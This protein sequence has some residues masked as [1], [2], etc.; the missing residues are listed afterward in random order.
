MLK[1]K[2]PYK[3][4]NLLNWQRDLVRWVSF[5]LRD[6]RRLRFFPYWLF[7]FLPSKAAF[8]DGL[9][10]IT[11]EAIDWL[12]S[13]LTKN[14]NVF[15]WGSGGSTLFFAKKAKNVVS[16]EHQPEWHSRISRK[17]AENHMANC[18]YILKEPKPSSNSQ[19]Y[20][21]SSPRYKNFSFEEYCKA[22]EPY[23]DNFFDLI[24][25]DGRA[26]PSCISLALKKLR[27]NGFLL[28]DDSNVAEYK[29]SRELLKDWPRKDFLGPKPYVL[30]FYQTTIWQKPAL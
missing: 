13:Y 23:P 8:K 22:I 10:W 25:I 19:N 17:L 5:V 29:G 21:S 26:R 12:N 20:L 16:L 27:P 28:L 30:G 3:V 18:Q 14:M 1:L 2:I 7:S 24:S 9:P 4:S 15:E 11:F 6:P